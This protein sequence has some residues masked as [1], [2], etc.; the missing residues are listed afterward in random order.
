MSPTRGRDFWL[1][2]IIVASIFL[3][4]AAAG[5]V[6]QMIVDKNFAPGN[7]GAVF[8]ADVVVPIFLIVLYLTYGGPA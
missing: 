6:K 5:H 2:A 8:A 3:L 7:A 1:A 4:G